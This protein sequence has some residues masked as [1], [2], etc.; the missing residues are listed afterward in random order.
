MADEQE[1]E[2]ETSSVK[3]VEGKRYIATL[4]N[5]ETFY[6]GNLR[7]VKGQP[8]VVSAEQAQ[9]LSEKVIK[10]SLTLADESAQPFNRKRFSIKAASAGAVLSKPAP[11]RHRHRVTE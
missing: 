3:I 11:V 6:L 1:Q 7:F 5:G 2:L 4:V 10:Q 9:R 8:Q